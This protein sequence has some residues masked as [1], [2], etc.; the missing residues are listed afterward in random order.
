MKKRK[1]RSKKGGSM[2]CGICKQTFDGENAR[3]NLFYHCFNVHPNNESECYKT[4]SGVTPSEIE[5][6][7]D[8]VA[9]FD[10]GGGRRKKRR[11]K[12]K[13]KRRKKLFKKKFSKKRKRRKTRRKRKNRK[14]RK[15]RR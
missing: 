2:Y 6:L 13:R 11:R 8:D 4:I 3:K 15:T 10:L 7:R 9:M 1:S 5:E 14:R 12:T